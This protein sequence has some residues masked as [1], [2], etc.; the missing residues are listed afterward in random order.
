MLCISLLTS[1]L[2]T[3]VRTVNLQ[4]L[5]SR[6]LFIRIH[7][8]LLRFCCKSS[9]D[10]LLSPKSFEPGCCGSGSRVRFEEL[11]TP[12]TITNLHQATAMHI[13]VLS[14]S[15]SLNFLGVKDTAIYHCRV[16][17]KQPGLLKVCLVSTCFNCLSYCLQLTPS[18]WL[19]FALDS[20]D[21]VLPLELLG[22]ALFLPERETSS[23]S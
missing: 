1:E 22:F 7:A 12:K 3:V 4:L 13:V 8:I 10:S 23:R 21:D 14:G 15:L 9:N 17:Q 16:Y 2:G 19:G 6:R 18:E 20:L 5:A 11:K